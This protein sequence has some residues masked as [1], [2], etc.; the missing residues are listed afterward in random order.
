M[1]TVHLSEEELDKLI[2]VVSGRVSLMTATLKYSKEKNDEAVYRSDCATVFP[3]LAEWE[4]LRR[5]LENY[6][7]GNQ[8]DTDDKEGSC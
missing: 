8:D 5:K 1:R 2:E 7:N 4:I 6:K 3:V